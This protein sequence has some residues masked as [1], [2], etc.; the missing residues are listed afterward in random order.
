MPLLP[1]G[2]A[3]SRRPHHP[4]RPSKNRAVSWKPVFERSGW[5]C[6]PAGTWR[7]VVAAHLRSAA[8]ELITRR[9]LLCGHRR[10]DHK[11]HE[12]GETTGTH[13]SHAPCG[14]PRGWLSSMVAVEDLAFRLSAHTRNAAQSRL[15]ASHPVTPRNRRR[16]LSLTRRRA[17][18]RT[19]W[20][21]RHSGRTF[22]GPARS[23]LSPSWH[24][25]R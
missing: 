20:R 1:L 7:E 22:V 12:D 16:P 2:L 15:F 21:P 13:L 18:R 10:R 6:L 9:R 24:S 17:C 14:P 5:R 3:P 25:H 11:R 23:T 19:R 8:E 4:G